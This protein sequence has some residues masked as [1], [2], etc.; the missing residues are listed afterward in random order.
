M[1]Y[2]TTCILMC[3]VIGAHAAAAPTLPLWEA[4]AIGGA[5]S[6]PAYP[7]SSD[8]STRGIVFPYLVYRGKVFRSDE[9]G[10]LARILRTERMELDLGFAASLPTRSGGVDARAGMPNLGALGEFGP[11][12]KVKVGNV[13]TSKVRFELPVRA[14]IEARGGLRQRGWTAE[15]R[16]SWGT[17]DESKRLSVG[18]NFSAVFGDRSINRYFYE[19]EPQFATPTRP[20]YTADSGLV[21][22]RLGASANYKLTRD[23]RLYG[24]VRG[25]SYSRSANRESPLHLKS[26]GFAGGFAVAWIIGRSSRPAAE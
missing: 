8:R 4:G 18:T 14:V 21:L 11:R 7:A 10:L 15:P 2:P 13:E 26:T 22:L 9:S 16:L 6:M 24:Y 17:E 5:V 3:A 19:V 12:L 23:L 20:A 1:R 25:E